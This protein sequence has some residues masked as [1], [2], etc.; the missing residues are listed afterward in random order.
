M[1]TCEHI[2]SDVVC[3]SSDDVRLYLSGW[4]CRACTPAAIR[5]NSETR[6]SCVCPL[7]CYAHADE[8][9]P[10]EPAYVAPK[11]LRAPVDRVERRDWTL[12]AKDVVMQLRTLGEFTVSDVLDNTGPPPLS[13]DELETAHLVN[14][15][16]AAL[17]HVG[18]STEQQ[19]RQL[20]AERAVERLLTTAAHHKLVVHLER[21]RW[22]NP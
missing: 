14:R 10:P 4:C 13:D 3:G 5:G 21:D 12:H 16:R 19:D 7:R 8:T 6:P 15:A 22:R 17:R 1:R 20:A 11:T 2:K 18:G 9:K